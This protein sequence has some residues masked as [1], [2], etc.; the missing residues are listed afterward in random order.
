MKSLI[1]LH[2][3]KQDLELN[4]QKGLIYVKK[5]QQ[6]TNI[7]TNGS[8]LLKSKWNKYIENSFAIIHS[9]FSLLF[10]GNC[11]FWNVWAVPTL[12]RDDKCWL[13]RFVLRRFS[14]NFMNKNKSEPNIALVFVAEFLKFLNFSG[15]YK[16]SI[17]NI[18]FVRAE[19]DCIWPC[20]LG[21]QNTPIA[22]M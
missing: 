21:L 14:V 2:M 18:F 6:P 11:H 5:K 12:I 19:S 17:F 20:W 16:K 22:F 15:R 13:V 9:F 8:Y 4:N 7:I 1:I 10:W 3:Y